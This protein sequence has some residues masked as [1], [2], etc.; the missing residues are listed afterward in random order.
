MYIAG[1]CPECIAQPISCP[2]V[3]HGNLFN[4]GPTLMSQ[5]PYLVLNPIAMS[6]SGRCSA[7]HHFSKHSFDGII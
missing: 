4:R 7:R 1:C 6:M 3:L 5:G 2:T